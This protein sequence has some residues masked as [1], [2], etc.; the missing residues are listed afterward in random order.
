VDLIKS[1]M[2]VFC[3]KIYRLVN[4]TFTWANS[5]L[6]PN[7]D[8]GR[9]LPAGK[10]SIFDANLIK[11]YNG[12]LLFEG[13]EKIEKEELNKTTRIMEKKTYY[14]IKISNNLKYLNDVYN[15]K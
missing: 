15:N 11:Y 2:I 14:R 4:V 1:N 12:G 10:R 13:Y 8:I 6:F 9:S 3:W 5:S 7:F